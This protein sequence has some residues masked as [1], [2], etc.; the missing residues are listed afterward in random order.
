MWSFLIEL[1]EGLLIALNIIWANKSRSALTT[2]GIVIGICSVVLMSTAI[3]GINQAFEKGISAMGSDNLYIDKWAWF[4]NDEWWKI[5]N[6]KNL[7]LDDFERFKE[8]AKLPSAV[9]PSLWSIQTVQRK[10]HNIEGV[11]INGTNQDYVKTTNFEFEQGRF[12]TEMESRGARPVVIIGSEIAK[13][14]FEDTPAINQTIKIGNRPYRVLGVLTQQ[15]NNLMGNANPDRSVYVP[16]QTIYKYFQPPSFRSVTIV[17]KAQSTAML[18]ET[19]NEA[20]GV[21]R[22]VR[23]LSWQEENDFTINQQE[24]LV[25]DYNRTVGVIQI[26]GLFITG[27]SLLVGAIGI[28]NIMFVSVKERT[29]EIG[30]RKAI[31]AKNRAILGQF[32]TEAATI[33]LIGGTIGL[34]LALALSQLVNQVLPTSFQFETLI[35]AIVI[36]LLT[37]VV[38]GFAPAWTAAKLDPVESLRYE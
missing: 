21:M 38:S 34:I 4:S 11:T 30:V 2:L 5:R 10:D 33:C 28:M 24:A 19:K 15:G 20:E 29:R 23:G 1:K 26:A 8:L 12:F 32:I 16:L 9:A 17:V 6:R 25:E 36:S 7:Q 37:G 31:G 14:L 22:K 18:M 27:L 3:Q 35:L 13:N